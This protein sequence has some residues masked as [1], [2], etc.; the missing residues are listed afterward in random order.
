MRFSG[1]D[2]MAIL[3]QLLYDDTVIPYIPLLIDRIRQGD[4]AAL[5]RIAGEHLVG[6]GGDGMYFCVECRDEALFNWPDDVAAALDRLPSERRYNPYPYDLDICRIWPAGDVSQRESSSV[7]SPIPAL[8]LAG[9]FDPITPPTWSQAVARELP[10]A[11]YIEFP[12]LG[13]GVSTSA[14][15]SESI[16]AFLRNPLRSPTPGCLLR[17]VPPVFVLDRTEHDSPY[18]IADAV[19]PPSRGLLDTVVD[20]LR[21]TVYQ[22]P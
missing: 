19:A 18:G 12:Y 8:V 1:N 15:G 3:F 10:N 16:A 22:E 7:R 17:N 4:Y 2:L 13:H 20:F 5:A 9:G 14:C 6:G 21:N 11:F